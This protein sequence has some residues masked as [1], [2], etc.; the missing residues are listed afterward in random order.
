VRLVFFPRPKHLWETLL[1]HL[2]G[3]VRIAMPL[4]PPVRQLVRLLAPFNSQDEGPRF[5]MPVL[6]QIK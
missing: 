5:V 4:P 6:V 2:T 3:Q 1:E